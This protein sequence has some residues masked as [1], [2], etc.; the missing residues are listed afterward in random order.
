[1]FPLRKMFMLLLLIF[2]MFV[3]GCSN[4]VNEGNGKDDVNNPIVTLVDREPRDC[5]FRE[6]TTESASIELD[7]LRTLR[8]DVPDGEGPPNSLQVYKQLGDTSSSF[9]TGIVT[10]L[11]IP[12][13]NVSLT[14][15]NTDDSWSMTISYDPPLPFN[16]VQEDPANGW[17]VEFSCGAIP[18]CCDE[19]SRVDT[20]FSP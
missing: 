4:M 12:P 1:M 20:T 8:L 11:P 6:T 10:L 2:V 5:I 13:E 3:Y 18:S 19:T 17:V 9:N 16:I 15:S 14:E 7:E